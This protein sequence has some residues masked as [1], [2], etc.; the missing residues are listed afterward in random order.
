MIIPGVIFL[1]T[2]SESACGQHWGV[3]AFVIFVDVIDRNGCL[4]INFHFF[5]F[6]RRLSIFYVYWPKFC[7]VFSLELPLLL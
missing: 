6:K 5:G 1:P 7:F 2:V 3:S 4:L